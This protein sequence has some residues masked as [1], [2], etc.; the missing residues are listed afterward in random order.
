MKAMKGISVWIWVI[1]GIIVGLVLFTIFIQFLSYITRVKEI[2]LAK[3][4]FQELVG[5]ARNIC[6]TI[7][8]AAPTRLE[9][10]Y[11]FP[12]AVS[13]IY[14]AT[15]ASTSATIPL[16]ER[17]YGRYLCMKIYE[18]T[19]CE[20]VQCEVEM[21]NIKNVPSLTTAISKILGRM[22][23]N[24]YRMSITKVSCGV[25]ILKYGESPLDFCAAR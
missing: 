16:K 15:S 25:S 9:K 13:N 7:G 23:I 19:F 18:E 3:S 22:G 4:T 2:E 5:N 20:D 17:S 6:K 1:G 14:S 21:S 12:D 10:T 24:E 11:V 8:G